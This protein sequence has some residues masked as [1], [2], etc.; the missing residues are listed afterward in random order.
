MSHGPG[1]GNSQTPK[2]LDLVRAWRENGKRP[3]VLEG[4]RV[5]NGKTEFEMPLY[6]YPTKAT[7]DAATSSYQPKEG[8]R[9]GIERVA[10]RFR[11]AA[12]E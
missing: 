7:W 4:R 3:G 8:P 9:G 12:A 10:A 11:P 2:N 6:P 1:P 5:V